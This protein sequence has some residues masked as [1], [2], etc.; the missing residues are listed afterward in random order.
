MGKIKGDT[1]KEENVS[2]LMRTYTKNRK[3]TVLEEI[4]CI[5]VD[6]I[7]KKKENLRRWFDDNGKRVG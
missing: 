7:V 4:E 3:D 6:S 2:K 1:L 5:Y